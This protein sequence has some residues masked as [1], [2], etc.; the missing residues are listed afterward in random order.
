MR[1]IISISITSN[2]ML[3]LLYC[4]SCK[5][6]SANEDILHHNSKYITSNFQRVYETVIKVFLLHDKLR[7]ER[8]ETRSFS[9]VVHDASYMYF[10]EKPLFADLEQNADGI[11]AANNGS[12]LQVRCCCVVNINAFNNRVYLRYRE[13]ASFVEFLT[14]DV[15]REACVKGLIEANL[16]FHDSPHTRIA[17]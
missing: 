12:E 14:F 9:N 8:K 2:V 4:Y 6:D 7:F 5:Y 17:W 13:I 1:R 16:A 3:I 15:V 10:V 11:Y